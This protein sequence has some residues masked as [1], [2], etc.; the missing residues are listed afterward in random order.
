[1]APTENRTLASV[2]PHIPHGIPAPMRVGSPVH[3]PWLLEAPT[4]RAVG[5]EAELMGVRAS[6]CQTQAGTSHCF[7]FADV[8]WVR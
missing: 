1:M 2:S 4:V 6:L 5:S 8:F 7:Q 3:A